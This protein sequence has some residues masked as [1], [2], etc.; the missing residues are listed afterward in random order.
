M[1]KPVCP[2]CN[3][4]AYDDTS[5]FCYRCGTQFSADIPEKKRPACP[6]SGM[7]VLKKEPARTRDDVP[8]VQKP[9]PVN[10][11][12]PVEVCARCDEPVGD[13]SRIYCTSCAAFVR[14][15]PL[16]EEPLLIHNHFEKSRYENPVNLPGP[17][18]YAVQRTI[19]DPEPV[20]VQTTGPVH[21]TETGRKLIVIIAGIAILFIMLMLVVLLMFTFWASLY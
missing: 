19:R 4:Q 11:I 7:R 15:V 2:K 6:G 16:K 18:Q 13:T 14:D 9:V 12:T 1:I 20:P 21:R 17:N 3:F 8:K 10:R 5:L